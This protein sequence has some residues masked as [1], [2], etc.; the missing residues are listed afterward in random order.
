MILELTLLGS[1]A[2]YWLKK[3]KQRQTTP[4]NAKKKPTQKS[5]S[6]KRLISDVRS[7][8]QFAEKDELLAEMDGATPSDGEITTSL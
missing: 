8:M 4:N 3:R 7:A 2:A 1:G 6:T 5:I